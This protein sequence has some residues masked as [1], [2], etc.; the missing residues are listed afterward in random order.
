MWLS[1]P[2]KLEYLWQTQG[3]IVLVFPFTH[4]ALPNS[5]P[6]VALRQFGERYI[7]LKNAAVIQKYVSH[8]VSYYKT[9]GRYRFSQI[10][11]RFR[12]LT[13]LY[14][15]VHVI[16]GQRMPYLDRIVLPFI[17]FVLQM[18][19]QPSIAGTSYILL[20]PLAWTPP[21]PSFLGF[22]VAVNKILFNSCTKKGIY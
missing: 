3:I 4:A 10:R 17:L 18:L 7:K 6:C 14:N 22:L 15:N 8:N 13:C 5:K 16:H 20:Y 2:V 11:E 9:I 12:W 1:V 19:P 21:W